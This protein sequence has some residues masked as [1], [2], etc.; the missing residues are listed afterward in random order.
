MKLANLL[1]ISAVLVGASSAV[2]AGPGPQFWQQQARNQIVPATTASAPVA[3]ACKC[4][5]A[6]CG[7][8]SS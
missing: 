2:F 4:A 8:K 7:A 1:L 3:V 5:G 6:C